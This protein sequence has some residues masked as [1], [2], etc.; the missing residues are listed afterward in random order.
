MNENSFSRT[1]TLKNSIYLGLSSM[2]GAGLFN[3]IAP[4]AKISSY[5]TILGLL[6]ASTLA[7]ANASSSAQLASLYPQTGGTYLYAKNILGKG[8][9]NVAGAV[10]IIGKTISC[11]AIAL[12]LGNYLSPVNSKEFAVLFSFVVFLIGFSGI[13]KTAKIAKWFVWILFSLLAFYTI[14]I[15]ITPEVSFNLPI[16]D[17][18]SLDNILLSGSIWFFAF[19][20]YS[21]LAT[22]GEEVKNPEKIIPT[23]IFTGLGITVII[24]LLISWV[25]LSIVEPQIIMNSRT[26][27]LIAMDLSSMSEFSFLIVFA[28]S[29]AMAS[30]FLALMPGISRIYVAMARDGI[31]PGA[32]STIHKKF[33]S[34]YISELIV[35]ITV[36]V[37]IY[38]LNVID[39]IKLSS[40]F[41]LTYYAITNL[42]VIKLKKN[43][44][45]YSVLVAYYGIFM[46]IVFAS[47][48]VVL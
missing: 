43:Q 23:A 47:S 2:I 12:T 20:G 33:N 27:L 36:V 13:H 8:A 15:V 9:A 35:F 48:L 31:L 18:L 17:Q 30:V 32:L 10:F 11:I 42:S 6:L 14:S 24:Y 45:I 26:P 39:S 28:S 4:T 19:T 16:T 3:N 38:Q 25:T 21:R 1:L 41:I 40:F 29:I 44:R 22:F 34:A 5:S 7:F 37:G 46:C